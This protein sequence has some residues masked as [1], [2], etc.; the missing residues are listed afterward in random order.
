MAFSYDL[1]TDIG[2]VRF[3]IPD[4]DSTAYDLEDA[5]IEYLLEQRGDS[6][7][8]AA[9][10]CCKWLARM[11]AKKATFSDA[12]FSIHHTERA[13]AFAKRAAELAAEV[14]GSYS[15]VSITRSDGYSEEA[16]DSEY[17]SRIVYIEI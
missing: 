3:L 12:G 1:S 2:K 8:A 15:T 6:V 7:N 5:E 4:N 14:S 16:T 11:Y 9:V 17:E 10:D 13:E